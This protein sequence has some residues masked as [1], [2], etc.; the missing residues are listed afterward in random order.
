MEIRNHDFKLKLKEGAVKEY[1][2][3]VLS[4][5]F[6]DLFM[7]MAFVSCEEGELVSYHC[8][9][10]TALRQCRISDA[11][12][13]LDILETIFQMVHKSTEY[14]ITPSKITLDMNTIFYNKDT[15]QVKIAYVPVERQ[16]LSLRENMVGFITQMENNVQDGSY[17]YLEAVKNKIEENNYYISDMVNL[18]G[19]MKR[20]MQASP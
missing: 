8:S 10:Y 7:P 2:K 11:K 9:G 17:R 12:E 14:L 5:G 20:S 16:E 3:V 18:I 6:C 13:A 19:E 15:R 1:E 4:S